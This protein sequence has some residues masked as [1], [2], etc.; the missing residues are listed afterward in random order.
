MKATPYNELPDF[1]KRAVK[2]STQTEL[3]AGFRVVPKQRH[4]VCA[5]ASVCKKFEIA[6]HGRCCYCNHEEQCH[7]NTLA[8]MGIAIVENKRMP[9]GVIAICGGENAV[10]LLV[11]SATNEDEK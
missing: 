7:R 1:V 6:I 2:P 8:D 3:E 5:D 4:C 11:D 9:D 10:W